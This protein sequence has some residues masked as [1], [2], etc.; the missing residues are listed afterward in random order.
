MMY[1]GLFRKPKNTLEIRDGEMEL[2]RPHIADDAYMKC[3]DC[4]RTVEIFGKSKLS[5]IALEYSLPV[6]ARLPIDPDTARLCD[7]GKME[8][9]NLDGVMPAAELI[10]KVK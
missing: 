4:G 8:Q 5:E 3:P 2:S 7:E 1:R 9:V 6:L 10:A